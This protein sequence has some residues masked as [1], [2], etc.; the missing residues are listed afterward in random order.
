MNRIIPSCRRVVAK[1]VVVRHIES[2]AWKQV[3]LSAGASS[4]PPAALVSGG[5]WPRALQ[6][7]RLPLGIS[8]LGTYVCGCS[9]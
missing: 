7:E 9:G 2:S 6:Y 5:A 4:R 8:A 1:S 3:L